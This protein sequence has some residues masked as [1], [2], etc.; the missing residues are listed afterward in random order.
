MKYSIL[1]SP[2]YL[3]D[4]V[5]D[6][7]RELLGKVLVTLEEGCITSGIIT[8][9]EAYAGTTDKA[10]HAWGGRKTDRTSIMYR[11][12]GLAYVYLCYGIH[13][14]FNVVTNHEGIPHAV[15]IRAIYPLDGINRMISRTGKGK[16]S[17]KSG[18]GPGNAARLLGIHY[19]HSGLSL[20][21]KETSNAFNI[22]I[23]D[24][25]MTIDP[26]LII[27]GP[28]VGVEYAGNDALRPYRF[29]LPPSFRP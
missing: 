14:L 2:F 20:L 3:R 6:I 15:L 5:V 16:I 21:S 7:A 9:T 27:E 25:S 22:W 29:R 8:E 13:S 17:I 18:T 26:G 4:N 24:R 11:E 12:G 10:S 23:E 1:P 28:R 19:S